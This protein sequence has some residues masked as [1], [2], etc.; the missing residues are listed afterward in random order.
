VYIV[1]ETL[2]I[3]IDE[4]D[5]FACRLLEDDSSRYLLPG[6]RLF[7][8]FEVEIKQWVQEASDVT[9]LEELFLFFQLHL[10]DDTSLMPSL[11]A[12]LKEIALDRPS[13]Y[14]TLRTS[15]QDE[16]PW[17]ERD[18]DDWASRLDTL[19]R[20]EVANEVP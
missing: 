11:Q 6:E 5:E 3:A 13:H 7:L 15:E 8:Y 10:R 4:A 20:A 9:Q 2:F 17:W 14:L 16:E 19:R 12:R 1:M 18:Y